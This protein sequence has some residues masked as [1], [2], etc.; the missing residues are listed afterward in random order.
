MKY[1]KIK[2]VIGAL[3]LIASIGIITYIST[4]PINELGL[5]EFVI[6][7]FFLILCAIIVDKWL[8][9]RMRD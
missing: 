2:I 6:N 3:C 9:I 1:E 5:Y 8:F 7:S 4:R